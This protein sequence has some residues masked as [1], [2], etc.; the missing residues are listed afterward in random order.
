MGDRGRGVFAGL[1][2]TLRI[3]LV[4][5]TIGGTACALLSARH[6]RLQAAHE[7]AQAR[8]RV[9]DHDERLLEVRALIAQRASPEAVE[10]LIEALEGERGPF[11][12]LI[13]GMDP[14]LRSPGADEA[15]IGMGDR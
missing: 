8:L 15:S 2:M 3:G 1:S 6:A 14:V 7:L 5:L 4:V 11:V 13:E 12:P 10:R 9:R